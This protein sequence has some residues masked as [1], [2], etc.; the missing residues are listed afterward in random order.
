MRKRI[1]LFAAFL[2]AAALFT[3]FLVRKQQNNQSDGLWVSGTIELTEVDCAFKISGLIEELRLDEGDSVKRGELVARL[4]ARELQDRRDKAGASLKM[5]ES[6]ISQLLVAIEH[7]EQ[8]SQ[9]LIAQARAQLGAAQAN[10]RELLVGSR[11]QEIE[12]ARAAV[13]QASSQLRKATLEWER[14]QRLLASETISK[15]R[16]DVAKAAFETAEAEYERAQENYE[17]VREGPRKETIDAARSRVAE[18]KAALQVAQATRLGV[19]ELNQELKTARAQVK[20][21]QADLDLA[22]TLFSEA[23]LYA[24]ISGIVL[25]KNMEEGEIALPG[26]SVLTL[27][28]LSRV[29]LRAYINE[30]DLGRIKVG[31][32]VEVH[33]D[34]YPDKVYSGRLSYISSKAEFTPKQIQT[35]EERV[36]LV[37]RIK[38]DIENPQMELKSGMPADAKILVEDNEE[39]DHEPAGNGQAGGSESTE[40]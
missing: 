36:K 1:F 5:A 30:T 29:W 19:E 20:L 18:A 23:W 10:L 35:Q 37:Y 26:S 15:Q 3:F 27:G 2:A 14:A 39:T 25:S 32:P 17:L 13:D 9:G 22:E 34:T 31:Q 7:Q 8:N 6:R 24:P 40:R 38:I 16:W 4:D 12:Q 21:A 28:D 11:P 33:T